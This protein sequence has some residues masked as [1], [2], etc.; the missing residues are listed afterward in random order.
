MRR[1]VQ[2]LLGTACLGAVVLWGE[3]IPKALA[4]MEAFRVRDVEVRGARFLSEQEVEGLLVLTP[5]SSIWGE[6]ERWTD[7]IVSH[8]LVKTGRVTRKPPDGLLV[9]LVERI[10]I[11]FAPTPTLEPVDAEGYLLPLDPASY[12]LDLP[13]LF[14]QQKTP[15]GARLVPEEVRRLAAEVDHL[16]AADTAFL[17]LVSSIEWTE[18]GSLLVRWTDPRVDFLLP[19]RASPARLRAGLSA[20]A[21][22]VSKSP[23]AAPS[24]I[25]LRFSDQVVVRHQVD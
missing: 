20:L 11:A 16:M 10:P 4:T 1:D 13:I 21:D 15:K 9:S 7:R 3:R 2:I 19:S 5:E 25:D 22:A 18:K 17:Q 14:S 23:G 8:P 12:R 6:T 24:V